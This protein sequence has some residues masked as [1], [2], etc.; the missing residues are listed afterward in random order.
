MKGGY[1]DE[2]HPMTQ[3]MERGHRKISRVQRPGTEGNRFLPT[4]SYLG[5]PDLPG[6]TPRV[7]GP[8]KRTDKTLA[9][10]RG[11][12]QFQIDL[13]HKLTPGVWITS[14]TTVR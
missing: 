3:T 1:P 4:I 2:H 12:M 11:L 6:Q 14:E 13:R 10:N 5:E 8:T 9:K 7:K